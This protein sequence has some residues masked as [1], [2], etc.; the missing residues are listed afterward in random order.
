M[1]TMKVFLVIFTTFLLCSAE[2]CKTGKDCGI[3]A[4]CVANNQPLGKRS[5][6]GL[7]RPWKRQQ[8]PSYLEGGICTPLGVKGSGCLVGAGSSSN[9]EGMLYMCPCQSSLKCVRNYLPTY[10]G[11]LG[12]IG[13]CTE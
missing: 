10:V 5:L 13:V 2:E 4:C 12:K 3:D 1:C 11:G 6:I 7:L 8:L 9:D